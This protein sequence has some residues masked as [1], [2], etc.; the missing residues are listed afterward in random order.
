M[1]R[2]IIL[3]FLVIGAFVAT[4]AQPRAIGANLGGNIDFSYQQGMGSGNM[5]DIAVGLFDYNGLSATV[6]YDWIWNIEGGFNWYAGP[7]AG[8][9]VGGL[10]HDDAYFGLCIGG[11]IGVEYQFGIPL[12][13]S[14]DYR[15]MINVLG[16]NKG[17]WGQWYG[18]TVGVR[19]RF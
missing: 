6:C 17:H 2:F 11:M 19:Y 10:F 5:F 3:S 16:F 18:L 7:G 15:P 1:K 8:V 4:N 14:I 13:L 9:S 12:N